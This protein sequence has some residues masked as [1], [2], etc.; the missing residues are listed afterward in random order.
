MSR[1]SLTSRIAEKAKEV[2][3]FRENESSGLKEL[4]PQAFQRMVIA[5]EVQLAEN[6]DVC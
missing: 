1:A 3:L 6:T 4:D 5:L 2:G